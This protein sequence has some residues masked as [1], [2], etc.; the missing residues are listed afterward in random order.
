MT[1]FIYH[2]GPVLAPFY[3]RLNFENY[4]I[5]YMKFMSNLF[6]WIYSGG[7]GVNSMKRLK[8]GP[9]YKSLGT[10]TVSSLDLFFDK[11]SM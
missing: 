9:S 2:L 7:G 6:I 10:Q 8:G 11:Y 4:V 3:R 1:C 5:H